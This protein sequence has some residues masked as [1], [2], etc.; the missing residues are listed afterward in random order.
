MTCIERAS[1]ALNQILLKLYSAEKPME[2][3]H[4]LYE[5]GSAEYHILSEASDP[6]VAFLS[7]STAPLCPGVLATN[8]L[9]SYTIEM[10]KA[11]CPAVVEIAESRREGYQLT[12]KL[13]LTKIPRGKDYIKVIKEISTVHS[14]ILSS[15]LKE[16]LWNFNSDNAIKGM[17]KPIKLVYNPREPFFVIR[18]PQQ[19]IAVFPIRFAEKSDVIISTAFFQLVDVG[20]S[21][22]YAKAPPCSWSAI[23]PPELRGEAFEDLSTNGGFVSFDIS[24]HHVDGKRLDKTVWNLLNFNAYVRYH[25]KI[26]KGFI[27]R[28][29]RKRLE[30]LVEVLH[31]RESL[32]QDNEQITRHQDAGCSCT[33][34]LVRS[35]K[36]S[37]LKQ[38]W[39]NLGRKLKRIH[40][41]LKIQ[42]FG[43]FRQRWLRLPKFSSREYTKL[44]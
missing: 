33:K 39:G 23:P 3:D 28:R 5:F 25:V 34:R 37:I 17:H 41:R 16:I 20:S 13:N 8:E 21:D 44:D 14:V 40:F 31:H 18:Q 9:S 26:T 22:R 35:S 10:I 43:R 11:L 7:I 4:H 24:S 36:Y 19:I 27:Q 12:L 15:Q 6:R 42:G 2:I 38:R 29:M 32:E 30:N 1:P